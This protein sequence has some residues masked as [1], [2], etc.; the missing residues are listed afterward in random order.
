MKSHVQVAVI[1][2]GVVGA[3]VL[4]HLTKAGWKD[5]VLLERDELTS[6]STW[7]AAGGMHTVNGDPNVAKLQQYTIDLYKEIEEISGQSCGVHITGGV[8]LAGTRERMDWLRLVQARGRYLGM[9][10]ELISVDE[11]H[12]LFPILDKTQFMGALYDPIE[13]H[14]DPSGVTH[15]YAKAARVQGAEIYRFTPV[16]DLKPRPDGSWDVITEKGNLHA[17]H[18]VNAGGL[19]AREV[20]RMVGLE[21]PILAMEHQYLITEEIPEVVAFNET[22]GKQML[23]AIDFEGEIYMRQ[24][25]KGVLM[26]T[27][28]RAG[29]PWSERQTPWNFSHELLAPDLDRI[30]PSL[31]VGFKH[32]PVLEQAGIKQVING[33]FTFAP[34]GNPVIGPV[35]GLKNYWVACGVMAGFSQGGGVGLVLSNWMVNGDPGADVWGMD[36]ARYGD[37]ATLAYT[38]AKVRENYSRR[39]RI[40]F[41]NEELPAARPLRTTPVYDRLKAKSAVFGVGYGL[42]YPLW[43]APEGMEPAE[44]VTFKR[45]NAHGPVGEE[46]QAVRNAVGLIETSSFAKYEVTGPDA[47]G[48]LSHLLANRMPRQGRVVLTPMLNPDGKLIGDF[49]V[50]K[51]GPERFYLFGS[52]PAEDYHM[53]WFEAHLPE[54]GVAVR[55]LRSEILGFSVAGPKSREL[56]QRLTA[57]DL[58][59]AAFPFM[60]FRELDLG[61]IP[62]KVG[63]LT[64]TGDLGYEIWVKTDYQLALYELLLEAGKDLGLRQFGSRALGALRLEKSF[65]TWAR[66]FRPIYGP[67]EA[68][69]D[70]FV[71][72]EKND[73]I[74]RDA[75]LREKEEGPR[76]RLVTFAVDDTDVDVIGDEP[77]WHDGNVVGWV[78]SGGYAHHIGKSVALA[79]IPAE[80]AAAAGGF[81]IE[82]LGE[83][84]PAAIS[85][86][87]LF[88]PQGKRM[89]S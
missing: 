49:T 69:L 63:R 64:F 43:F 26:G 29:V 23:H 38:N 87:P 61:M 58:S 11:A 75:A 27:Y 59:N 60:S 24:E 62:V 47:E 68:G 40:R 35:R 50:A 80:L 8:M 12:K 84:K 9:Q 52:G 28:E 34:D 51:A 88:D 33:P 83:R 74:G 45:S 81:E 18:V 72:L 76:R 3:S 13:G 7:H 85:L 73:F 2:G 10:T 17:E 48:W 71:A 82:I 1:G 4:Y 89:R 5:V 20:G 57:E 16:T 21:L 37:W 44:E 54:R 41:P 32:Y 78:T 65:G 31:E 30:A 46:C 15:A 70:R 39:F 66:E 86:Q 79:Y 36:V 14:V 6:G 42:E 56:L 77:V 25:G 55:S 22:E 67:F 53:R 19:W